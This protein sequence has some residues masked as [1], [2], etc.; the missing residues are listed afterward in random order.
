M[1]VSCGIAIRV[2][3]KTGTAVVVPVLYLNKVLFKERD[4]K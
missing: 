1:S 2:R 4:T 3:D